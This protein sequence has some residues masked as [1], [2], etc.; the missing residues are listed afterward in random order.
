MTLTFLSEI[1]W[2]FTSMKWCKCLVSCPILSYVNSELPDDFTLWPT[3]IC[4]KQVEDIAAG[5]LVFPLVIYNR[6]HHSWVPFTCICF[7]F[8]TS[9]NLMECILSFMYWRW[10]VDVLGSC[11]L[12]SLYRVYRVNICSFYESSTIRRVKKLR[13]ALKK[14]VHR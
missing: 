10:I 11:R 9:T 5:V 8:S 2:T 7:F 4:T 12:K 13:E 14:C 6:S 1:I 3:L